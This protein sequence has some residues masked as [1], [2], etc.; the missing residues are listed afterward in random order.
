MVN[1]ARRQN[2]FG[3]SLC[4]MTPQASLADGVHASLV[5][6]CREQQLMK[7]A[8][9][10][11]SGV[12]SFSFEFFPPK[13]E[14]GMLRLFETI[15]ELRDY[16]PSYVSVTYGAGGSTRRLTVDLVKRIKGEIGLETMAHLTCVGASREQIGE[17]LDELSAGGVENVLALRGDPP[18]GETAFV[19]T[20][21]GFRY[22]SELVAFVK[23]GYPFCVAAACYPEGHPEAPGFDADLNHLK[24]KVDAGVDVLVTQLFFDNRDY[25]RFVQSA[26]DAGISIPILAGIMPI[27]NYSQV[28]RFTAMCGATI[29]PELRKALD[30]TDGEPD[31][32]S[33][34]GVAHATEQ[35]RGLI[36]G[37]APGI[38][39]YT[40]NRSNATR[41]VL[42]ALQGS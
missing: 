13:D 24:Q 36:A 14:D 38:H 17:V 1:Q 12:P 23:S 18:K 26:R 22:A 2:D 33:A 41:K 16:N 25:F 39:F 28:K 15:Q 7:I 20:D 31:Q 10:L 29:P 3:A 6:F 9:K 32:V 8:E 21:G 4:A 19:A 27:T 35:C 34:L 37:G 11:V 5:P 40:L 30:A 42:E